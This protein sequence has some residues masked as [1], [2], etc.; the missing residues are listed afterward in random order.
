MWLERDPEF[1]GRPL[2]SI[3]R[4]DIE[5]GTDEEKQQA[6]KAQAE[7]EVELK[8]V[9][10]AIRIQLQ[11]EI[12]EVRLSKRLTSSAAVLVSEEGEISPQMA[13]LMAAMGQPVP[14]VK[15]IFE[16]NGDHP[17]IQKM[18][19]LQAEDPKHPLLASFAKLLYGQSLLAEGGQIE[20][21]AA[22]NAAMLEVM[23]RA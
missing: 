19:T 5:L 16:L 6:E 20:D 3:G 2:K 8:E 17:V 18:K 9:L 11:D 1:S 12:K 23:G 10:N 15:R 7:K 13:K 21:P 4:G 22:F 14:K